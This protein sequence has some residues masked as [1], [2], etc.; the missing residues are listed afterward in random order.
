MKAHQFVGNMFCWNMVDCLCM[1]RYR[2]ETGLCGPR[3]KTVSIKH[4]RSETAS[5]SH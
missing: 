2:F 3:S 4:Y 1:S 5:M